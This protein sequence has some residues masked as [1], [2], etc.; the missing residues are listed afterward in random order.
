MVLAREM[1]PSWQAGE[2]R[3]GRAAG[4]GRWVHVAA[5][6]GGTGLVGLWVWMLGMTG[7]WFHNPPEKLTGLG[8][9]ASQSLR[10]DVD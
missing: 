2:A 1:A 3:V 8:Q 4:W 10:S 5:T 6:L 7:M 9:S